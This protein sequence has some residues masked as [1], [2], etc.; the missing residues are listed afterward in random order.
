[1][2]GGPATIDLWDMKPGAAT[3]GP[4]R[5]KHFGDVQICEHLPRLA[6]N[7]TFGNSAIDEHYRGGP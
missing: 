5:H 1:M 3:S 6:L 2:G 7:A 4:F